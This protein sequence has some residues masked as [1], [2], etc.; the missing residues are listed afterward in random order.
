[1]DFNDLF[2]R[3][4]DKFIFFDGAMGTMLQKSGLKAG[5]LPEILNITNGNTIKKIHEVYLDSG[6]DIIITNTFGAN[7]LK[8]SDSEYSSDEVIEA[9]VRVAKAAVRGRK[10]KFVALDMG[11]I[12]QVMEPTGN[13]TFETAYKL[14]KK[15]VVIGEREGADIIL[16]ET[17]M[18]IYETKAAILAAKENSSLPVFC[19]MTFQENARTLMGTDPRTM[20]FVL[21]G[22]G[23][24]ALGVNCSLG[25][26]DLQPIVDEI[27]RYSSTPVMVQPN[28]GLPKY[29]GKETYY[30]VKAA[31]FSE[32]MKIMAEKGVRILGGCCGTDPE[33]IKATIELVSGLKPLCPE[34]KEFT[35]VTSGNQ[36]VII[37]GRTRII[38]ERINP[39][40]KAAYKQE[41][42]EKKIGYIQ[43][44]ALYQK[45]E[46]A[47]ILELN[48][49][50]PEIDE[51]EMMKKA[52]K[53][54]Q[55]VSYLPVSIDSPN[56]DALEAG[57]RLYR[58]KPLI[59]SVNG[60]EKTMEEVFPIVKKY[61]G[62]I[63]ALTID[64]AGI[65]NTAEERFAI[66][67]K[68]VKR[69]EEFGISRKDIIVDC[70]SLTAS[71]Q[72]KEV[73]ETVR[74]IRMVKEKLG[75]KTTLGVSNVSYGLPNRKLLNRTFLLMALEAGLDLPIMNPGD[76]G[77]KDTIAAFEVL[78]YR[79][80]DSKNF[81]EKYKDMPKESNQNKKNNVVDKSKDGKH[82]K[83]KIDKKT[84]KQIIIDGMED[85]AILA[86]SQLLKLKKP[87]DIVNLYVIP[88]LDEVGA[89]YEAKE[90][91]LPQL[92]QSA[93]TVKK[94]FEVIK[95]S[96]VESG[97]SNVDKG[98]I[99]LAT[100]KG[101]I[102][103]IGKN[104]V[105][106]LLENY[107][108]NVIDLGKDVD[109]ERVVDCVK[110]NNIRVVGLSA[111]MTTTVIN[112]KKT[113]EALRKSNLCCKVIVGG[114]VLNQEY[115]DMIGADFYA[116]DARDTVK[117]AEKIFSQNE[118]EFVK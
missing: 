99:V 81:I 16:I 62:C 71:A 8:Y 80:V 89:K 79:D 107:G 43:R 96:M 75:V 76:E 70:L 91:F 21:E 59:N 35:A 50:L 86:T 78:S 11:P 66:A 60:K 88:A 83:D 49:G 40:G 45:E 36:T 105:K 77:M 69:A 37:G 10:D 103:D 55:Q 63:I 42:R 85:E 54:I 73:M 14:F 31:E 5:D 61:G 28:A 115:A 53:A 64:E 47:D 29:D 51:V 84:L 98:R 110:Q 1:M 117:I 7:E 13:L 97:Q 116:R 18:D 22:L 92:M 39:T 95:K 26:K 4:E 111:L 104:I 38:G 112:M 101:D 32:Q 74:A 12:G 65:A 82:Q 2:K 33:F 72:Q 15:Q 23:V 25:P 109:I 108:F 24:D 93:E 52:V 6:A 20:V 113:I 114:A 56:P 48:V 46:G 3:F 68:I 34:K 17:M 41:L 58:G 90:I 19:T 100:V 118:L 67:E 9:G 30:D 94:S 57:V 106:V 102:H 87:L 27:L 44:E